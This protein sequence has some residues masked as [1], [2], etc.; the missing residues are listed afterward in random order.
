MTQPNNNIPGLDA[1]I[2]A[3]NIK[4][5]E[6]YNKLKTGQL[7]KN[8]NYQRKLVWKRNHKINFIET[9]IKNYPFP[10]IYIAPS[11][12]DTDKLE[13]SEEI[14]DGQQRLNTIKNYIEGTDIF[15]KKTGNINNFIDLTSEEKKAFLNYEISVRYLKYANEEQ[16]KE[17]FQRINKTDYALNKVERLN[18]Q[19]GDSE[20]ICFAKQMIEEVFDSSITNKPFSGIM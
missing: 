5:I 1:S 20:F 19:W 2:P 9:I 15:A 4:I 16:V 12:L 8:E 13:F 7:K 10:E 14:V 3:N 18:A 11:K 17:I 6:L